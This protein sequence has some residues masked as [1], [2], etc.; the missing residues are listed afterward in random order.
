MPNY[1]HPIKDPC[2]KGFFEK[3]GSKADRYLS[4][5]GK[6]LVW[7][8]ES[9]AWEYDNIRKISNLDK[10]IKIIIG[11][12][13]LG[14]IPLCALV[15]KSIYRKSLINRVKKASNQANKKI[16]PIK[17]LN[18]K[19]AKLIN[20]VEND[21]IGAMI[22][23]GDW[24][25]KESN[26]PRAVECWCKA[27]KMGSSKAML[28]LG[29]HFQDRSNDKIA[30]DWFKRSAALDNSKAMLRLGRYSFNEGDIDNA[31]IWSEKAAQ[32]NNRNAMF[33]LGNLFRRRKPIDNDKA[34]LWF[35]KAAELGHKE[36]MAAL[37]AC[38]FDGRGTQK[39]IQAAKSWFLKAIE[40]KSEL[41]KYN[42]GVLLLLDQDTNDYAEVVNLFKSE[43]Q[44]PIGAINLIIAEQI[45]Y[46]EKKLE[47]VHELSRHLKRDIPQHYI[48]EIEAGNQRKIPCLDE[49]LSFIYN[50]CLEYFYFIA[51][52]DNNPKA[53]LCLGVGELLLDKNNEAK[54]W[55]ERAAALGDSKAAQ[56]LNP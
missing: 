19:A 23:L 51:R 56:L 21:E 46:P 3:I 33:F 48:I 31:I 29:R 47:L 53:M 32:K 10:A 20:K 43:K 42:L 8:K 7:K 6:S 22:K 36:A 27:A 17:K 41:A 24:H 45:Q 5:S 15:V 55:L 30:K 16:I 34:F 2:N 25:Q 14:S 1:L 44:S 11:L 38:F 12:F 50:R 18:I 37:G 52:K 40:L 39:D 9:F 54:K 4:W 26:D 35:K 49:E 28:K 13:S